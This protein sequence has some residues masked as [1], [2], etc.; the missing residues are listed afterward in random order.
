M[1]SPCI[2]TDTLIDAVADDDGTCVW[3]GDALDSSDLTSAWSK[4]MLLHHCVA[5]NYVAE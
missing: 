3:P 2:P 5:K 1:A 4:T